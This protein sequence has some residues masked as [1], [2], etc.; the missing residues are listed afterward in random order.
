MYTG[1]SLDQAPPFEAP[2]KFFLTAPLFATLTGIIVFFLDDLNMFA[3]QTI[4]LVHILTIGFM[5]MIIFGALLQMLPVV[6]GAV[7][8][9]PKIVANTTYS[10]LVIGV[11]SFF[12]GFY[13]YEKS[14]LFISSISLLT[15]SVVFLGICLYEL[16]KV[17]PK[18]FIVQGMIFSTFFALLAIF[19]GIYMGISHAKENISASYFIF[20]S[21]H[22]NFVFIGFIFLLIASITFQ[23]VPMFW[24]TNP[25]EKTKQKF[26]IYFTVVMLVIFSISL[27]S[28]LQNL[29]FYKI[30]LFFICSYFAYQ[31][32]KTIISRKRKLKDL[33]VNYYL[34]SMFF[35]ILGSLYFIIYDFFN[36]KIEILAVIWGIGFIMSIMNGMLYKIVPFLAWFHLSS[37]GFFD[38]PTI[39]DMIPPKQIEIQFFLHLG[40]II[41][42]LLFFIFE[43]SILLKLAAV[44]FALS[45]IYLFFNLFKAA[46]VYLDFDT[47]QSILN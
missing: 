47:S 22:Y 46:K 27:L 28:G 25:F 43:Y 8:K 17:K 40:A 37:K 16:M 35:L 5:M 6:A 41:F 32:I 11:I 21:I 4:G 42:F 45:N 30:A 33:S 38:I 14:A 7:I 29:F 24:V 9:K 12:L 18:S 39:R 23:V 2:L 34:T 31:T 19:I 20:T 44:V 10:F 26:I 36:L 3:R 13:F 15:A 1:L